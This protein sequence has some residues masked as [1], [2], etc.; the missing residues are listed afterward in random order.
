MPLTRP[1]PSL[2]GVLAVALT[3]TALAVPAGAAA[4]EPAPQETDL[5]LVTGDRVH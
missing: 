5:T 4:R 3:A 1:L 2:T